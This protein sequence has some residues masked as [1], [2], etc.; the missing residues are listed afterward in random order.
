M[1]KEKK[2]QMGPLNKNSLKGTHQSTMMGVQKS[3]PV[4][5]QDKRPMHPGR[6]QWTLS[7]PCWPRE[8]VWTIRYSDMTLSTD[9]KVEMSGHMVI[10]WGIHTGSHSWLHD[11]LNMDVTRKVKWP[12]NEHVHG[13]EKKKKKPHKTKRKGHPLNHFKFN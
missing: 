4:Q 3:N 7:Q 1:K 6:V 11:Q 12:E 13:K 9:L 8:P 5:A 10:Q 2:R